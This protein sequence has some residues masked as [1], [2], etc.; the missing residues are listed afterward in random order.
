MD[1]LRCCIPA[2]LED[3]LLAVKVEKSVYPQSA[4]FMLPRSVLLLLLESGETDCLPLS[5]DMEMFLDLDGETEPDSRTEGFLGRVEGRLW[6][7]EIGRAH[8]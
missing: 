5:G 1:C 3:F 6:G 7:R 8:V 2:P 4:E